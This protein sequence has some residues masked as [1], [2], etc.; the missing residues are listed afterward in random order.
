VRVLKFESDSLDDPDLIIGPN[1]M[2][3]AIRGVSLTDVVYTFG[4]QNP[5]KIK[6]RNFPNW[7]RRLRRRNGQNLEELIDL[8]AIDIIR[9]RERGVPRYNRFREM[10]HM[11]R[12]K[13]FEEMSDDRNIVDT[14]RKIY[15]HPDKVDLMV[16]M[17]AEKPPKGF[18]FS[19]TAFRVF[20]LMA[21]RRLKSDRFLTNDFNETVYT[22]A[23]L[24]WITE[25]NMST[26]LLRHF[27]ELTPVLQRVANPFSPWPDPPKLLN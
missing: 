3:N 14:L 15:G 18:G 11:P 6:L 24:D 5:G 16:G 7:M 22:K 2:Q 4:V 23:G 19:D 8:A 21:P 1:A 17:Y 12:V 26:V 13:T 20:I 9:D 10:F 25:N 27:P